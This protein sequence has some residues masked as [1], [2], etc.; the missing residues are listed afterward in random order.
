MSPLSS[1]P[2]MA[3]GKA[4]DGDRDGLFGAVQVVEI[5]ILSGRLV[6]ELAGQNVIAR[7]QVGGGIFADDLVFFCVM[8]TGR[9]VIGAHLHVCTVSAVIS[10][11]SLMSAVTRTIS[12]FSLALRPEQG[13][14]HPE[15][16]DERQEDH[17][18][19]ITVRLRKIFHMS[20]LI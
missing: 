19:P 10:S 1:L 16:D 17:S 2:E 9:Q 5:G 15:A 4:L 8:I 3:G 7:L 18:T 12:V 6:G 11:P 13:V 20:L 14:R